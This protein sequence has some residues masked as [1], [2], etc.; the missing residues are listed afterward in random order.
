[1]QIFVQTFKGIPIQIKAIAGLEQIRVSLGEKFD[2]LAKEEQAKSGADFLKERYWADYGLRY[3]DVAAMA[4]EVADEIRGTFSRNK[5]AN[6]VDSE[7][8]KSQLKDPDWHLRLAAVQILSEKV[9]DIDLLIQALQ[10]DSSHVRR[11]AAAALGAAGTSEAV[12]ALS[13]TL[14]EDAHIGV[15]RTA[16]DA[17]SDIGDPL[18]Q[19]A[20]CR[21]LSDANK[22]VRWRAARFLSD[23]GNV[24]ALPF[25]NAA[26]ADPA[27]EVRLEIEAAKQRIAGGGQGI[28]PAWR[29]IIES[30]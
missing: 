9:A 27:F 25:L 30:T 29:R 1:M 22:L 12:P 13:K 14:T 6:L 16:G 11:L 8:I 17:L 23:L 15:R 21:A 20:M 26:A 28:G 19:G 3:G 18:A 7:T 5:S 4:N 2:L 10:D 24:E